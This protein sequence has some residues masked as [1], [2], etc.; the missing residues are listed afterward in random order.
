ME[1]N[2]RIR[3]I[4]QKTGLTQIKFAERVAIS[5]SY[6]AEIETG[7]KSMNE[8]VIRLIASEF[9]VNEHW[10]RSGEGEMFSL[11][12]DAEIATAISLF[13]TLN[14]RFR[15]CALAQLKDLTQLYGLL[16]DSP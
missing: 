11:N 1:F 14:K 10:L 16:N 15:E 9:N 2:E 4:R 5:S 3:A 6:L 8:R 13:R 12:M 7:V